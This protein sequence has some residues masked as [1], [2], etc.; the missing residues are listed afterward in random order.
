MQF[1]HR[2]GS[3]LRP[4]P[5]WKCS[6]PLLSCWLQLNQPDIRDGKTGSIKRLGFRVERCD[7]P[8]SQTS[9]L[10]LKPG[11]GLR[12]HFKCHLFD[13]FFH[14]II[15]F[16]TFFQLFNHFSPVRMSICYFHSTDAKSSTISPLA[17]P[18]DDP[19]LSFFSNDPT[20]MVDRR[21][22]Q[23]GGLTEMRT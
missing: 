14:S 8:I 13:F 5:L 1:R 6:I 22:I 11:S 19:H 9:L 4:A 16:G 21:Q 7:S 10:S 15:I 23:A 12:R 3:E 2:V 18:W 20:E 17:R